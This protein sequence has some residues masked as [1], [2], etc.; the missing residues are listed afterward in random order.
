M[1]DPEKFVRLLASISESSHYL[2]SIKLYKARRQQRAAARSLGPFACFRLRGAESFQRYYVHGWSY[3]QINSWHVLLMTSSILRIYCGD[4]VAY[5][6]VDA[7]ETQLSVH[8]VSQCVPFFDPVVS[9]IVRQ[10][11]YC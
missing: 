8:E 3:E 1:Q 10:V 11:T 6:Y 4:I 9:G 7:P 5:D 2:K